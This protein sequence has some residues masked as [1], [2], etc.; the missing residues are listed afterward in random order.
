MMANTQDQYNDWN[1]YRNTQQNQQQ[2]GPQ[3]YTQNQQPQPSA[4]PQKLPDTAQSQPRGPQYV[5]NPAWTPWEL[6]AAIH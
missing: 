2:S 6:D 4:Q 5:L 1:P 3:L